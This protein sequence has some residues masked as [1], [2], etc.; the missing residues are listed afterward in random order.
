M[1]KLKPCTLEHVAPE[2]V[3]VD[4]KVITAFFK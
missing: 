3:G 2:E 4:S 1:E